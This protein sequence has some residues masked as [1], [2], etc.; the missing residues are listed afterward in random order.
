MRARA[1]ARRSMWGAVL[2]ALGAVSAV[3]FPSVGH[4]ATPPVAVLTGD[5]SPGINKIKHIV[6][7]MQEN[8]SFD[9]YFGMYPGADGIP[10]DGSG[11]PTVCVP[12]P[13]Q[14]TCVAP[15]HDPEDENFGG[16][17]GLSALTTDVDGGNMDGFITS[18]EQSCVSSTD[19]HCKGNGLSQPDLMGYKLRDDIPNYWNYADNFVLQ[20]HMF[21]PVTGPSMESHLALVSGWSAYCSDP[22]KA[23]TCR[24]AADTPAPVGQQ[25]GFPWADSTLLMSRAGVSWGYYIFNGTEPDC[26]DPNALTCLPHAQDAPT[27]SFWNPLPKFDTVKNDGQLGNVQSVTNFVAN[28]QNGTLPS[29]SWVVPTASVSDHPQAKV[30]AGQQYITYLVN[31]LMQ[32]PEWDSTAVFL[33]WDDWGGFYDHLATPVVDGSG[34]GPRVPALLISPWAKHGY[35]DHQNMSFDS[36]LRLIEDRFLGGARI[37]P[38]TDGLHDDRPDVRENAPENGNL[39]DDF[40]FTQTPQP[41]D[42]LPTVAPDKLASPLI[43]PTV[44]PSAE[45]KFASANDAPVTGPAPLT[46]TFDGSQSNAP[47]DT[48]ASWTLD[49]GDGTTPDSGTGQPPSSISHT[50]TQAG[51]FQATL[52]VTDTTGDSGNTGVAVNVTDSSPHPTTWLTSLPAN[53]YTSQPVTFD[54]SLSASGKWSITFGDKSPRVKGSG[55][56]PSTLTH[57]YAHPGVYTATLKLRVRKGGVGTARATVSIVDATIPSATSIAP[58]I[59]TSDSATVSSRILP[60]SETADVSF[61]Y[62]T[63]TQFGGTTA[64]L[65]VDRFGQYDGEITGL[66]PGTKYF[67]RVVASNAIGSGHGNNLSFTTAP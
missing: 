37:D 45:Q 30:S 27:G 36:Y 59:L 40:D 5:A 57:S 19:R 18:F 34:F 10:V 8:R 1:A 33:T 25:K 21:E 38:K 35:I 29:V 39:L 56:P 46:V 67:F 48:I 12:D 50:Y 55:V 44:H 11:N 28:A 9:E 3:G 51:A 49:Y 60:N 16:P 62:G 24:N 17:H 26:A 65:T 20:D 4:A 13:A 23:S 15:F 61:Q 54:G 41:P 52:T 32:G 7:L 6:I 64:P 66:Q 63:T 2:L 58:Y 22:T 42:I 14:G 53:G 31:Q 43:V 47:G